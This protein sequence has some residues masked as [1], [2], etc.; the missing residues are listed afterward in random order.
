MARNYDLTGQRF[1]RLTVIGLNSKGHSKKWNCVCDCGNTTVVTTSHLLAG[2]T[3]SCGCKTHDD[4]INRDTK[5]G[6]SIT[7][8]RLCRIYYAMIGRCYDVTR[9]GYKNYGGRGIRVCCEWKESI[10]SFVL[11][12]L[13]HGYNDNLSIDR[14]DSNGN[15]EPENCRWVTILEQSRNKTTNVFITYHDETKVLKDWATQFGI[16]QSALRNRLKKG[17]N[18]EDALITPVGPTGK[19]YH[20]TA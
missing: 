5:H 15:Y 7:H 17:W 4:L 20:E 9:H 12:A 10:A 3:V 8:R 18:I 2:T 16:S 13:A 14:I 6:L 19:R 11:W 1:G